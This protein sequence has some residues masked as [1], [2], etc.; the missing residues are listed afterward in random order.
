MVVLGGVVTPTR[1]IVDFATPVLSFRAGEFVVVTNSLEMR[2]LDSFGSS[3]GEISNPLLV[4][5]G[6]NRFLEFGE[7]TFLGGLQTVAFT[8]ID[9]EAPPLFRTSPYTIYAP[10]AD[11]ATPQARM[12]LPP[13]DTHAAGLPAPFIPG[14]GAGGFLPETHRLTL[15]NR[16]VQ[17]YGSD[18]TTYG[19]LRIELDNRRIVFRGR[20]Y[21]S[22]GWWIVDT[23]HP[24]YIVF[25]EDHSVDMAELSEF[26]VER[27]DYIRY[28]QFSGIDVSIG[29]LTV[30]NKKR[31]V[32]VHGLDPEE[33]FAAGNHRV[34]ARR[35]FDIAFEY[36]AVVV[37]THEVQY[38]HRTVL[39][40]GAEPPVQRSPRSVPRIYETRVPI[41]FAGIEGAIGSSSVTFALQHVS[42]SGVVG[43][44]GLHHIA[45]YAQNTVFYGGS[46][47]EAGNFRRYQPIRFPASTHEDAIGAAVI[48]LAT[49]GCGCSC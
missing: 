12:N 10:S 33:G 41:R 27:R 45:L 49:P 20:N 2:G 25:E 26:A 28:V 9:P 36:D 22:A 35:W 48:S 5:G 18:P 40:V 30:A 4:L 16:R 14:T 31:T 39:V 21:L 44:V 34:G 47:F 1:H 23:P 24:L 19:V 6:D 8:S 32:F 15:R 46:Y 29:A 43:Q 42:V 17:M 38:Q 11:T 3:G 37:G 13:M 7:H